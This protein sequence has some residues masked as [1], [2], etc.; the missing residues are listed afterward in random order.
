M[1]H[2]FLTLSNMINQLKLYWHYLLP[3]YLLTKFAGLLANSPIK[4]LKNYLIKDFV[5]KF[6]INMDEALEA[7][8]LAYKT[9]NDFFTRHLKPDAR[10]MANSRMICPADGFISQGGPLKNNKL[11]QAKGI[12]YTLESLLASKEEA[13]KYLDGEFV[14]I[15][16][17][18]KDYHRVHMPM[19]AKLV[20]QTYIPGS[21]FS[22]QPF[23]AE[24]IPGLFSRNERLVMHF[25]TEWG[26]MAIILVGATVVGCIGTAWDGD[27]KRSHQISEKTFNPPLEI[28]KGMEIGYFKLGS[29]VIMV[30]P[31]EIQANWKVSMN[32]G[33]PLQWGQALSD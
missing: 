7:N 1:R 5:K 9:F 33:T 22:V 23:T 10:P 2:I 27:V 16:L 24:H 29:T 20:G 21:L 4:F 26:P 25:E 11:L 14:T 15:Y 31:K 8:P 17:S 18:P 13:Q 28:Q 6:S 12:Y 32:T 30:L 19:S 3:K